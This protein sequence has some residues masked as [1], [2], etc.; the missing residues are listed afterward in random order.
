[1]YAG[2]YERGAHIVDDRGSTIDSDLVNV[3]VIAPTALVADGNR[4]P[5]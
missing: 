1:V 2:D 5:L 3:T 4:R